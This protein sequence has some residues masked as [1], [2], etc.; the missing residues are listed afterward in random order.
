MLGCHREHQSWKQVKS[1]EEQL[2]GAVCDN[3]KAGSSSAAEE[4]N[5]TAHTHVV[6][7]K[8]HKCEKM[9]HCDQV[10]NCSGLLLQLC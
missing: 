3:D 2:P 7:R 4:M 6:R 5:N 10:I 9:Q 1:D 8:H